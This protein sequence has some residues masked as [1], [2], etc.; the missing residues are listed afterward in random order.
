[1]SRE[2]TKATDVRVSI[3]GRRRLIQAGL[4]AV[5]VIVSLRARQAFATDP[6][7]DYANTAYRYGDHIGFFR[8]PTP[9]EK[10][11]YG[12][13]GSGP[14]WYVAPGAEYKVYRSTCDPPGP[15]EPPGP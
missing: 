6:G 4:G 3:L 14:V 13:D 5:P 1:M 10:D 2:S 9:D 11:Y 7:T 12:Y 15:P 8:D